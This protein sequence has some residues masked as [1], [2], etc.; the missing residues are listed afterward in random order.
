MA[1]VRAFVVSAG[2]TPSGVATARLP[3][4][5]EAIV[6]AADGGLAA[7]YVLERGINAVIGD[8][9]SVDNDLLERARREGVAVQAH[10]VDKDATDL[11]LAIE[12]AVLQGATEVCV[13]DSMRGRVDHFIAAA[14]LL[15]SDRWWRVGVQAT[16]DDAR[17]FVVPPGETVSFA[18]DLGSTVS[19]IPLGDVPFVTTTGLQYRLQGEPLVAGGTGG[20]SNVAIDDVVTVR[21]AGGNCALLVLQP[22]AET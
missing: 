6:V 21:S 20:V 18:S 15:A 13:I 22:G 2:A 19:L 17:L 12:Y 16:I 8:F 10:A 14:L 11:D 9:D 3:D 1:E 5:P 7:A 4:W